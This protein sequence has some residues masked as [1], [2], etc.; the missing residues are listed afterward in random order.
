MSHIH[1]CSIFG[2]YCVICH[3]DWR[4]E[5]NPPDDPARIRHEMKMVLDDMESKVQQTRIYY[6]ER[7]RREN[8]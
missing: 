4:P 7:L 1:Q 5:W 8:P 3:R 2:P 6:E